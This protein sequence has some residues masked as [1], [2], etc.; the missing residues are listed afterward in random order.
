MSRHGE[1]AKQP[2]RGDSSSDPP[3]TSSQ[4]KDVLI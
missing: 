2:P 4:G 1:K 3:I